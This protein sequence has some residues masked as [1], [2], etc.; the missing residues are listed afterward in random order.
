VAS[1]EK[2]EIIP[3][4]RSLI[5]RGEPQS[6]TQIVGVFGIWRF[7]ILNLLLQIIMVLRGSTSAVQP[8]FPTT[9][10]RRTEYIRDKEGRIIEKV[11]EITL[12]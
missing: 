4:R 7:P 9:A 2:V 6:Q 3:Y 8:L 11:E 1:D 5:V 12:G 10:T